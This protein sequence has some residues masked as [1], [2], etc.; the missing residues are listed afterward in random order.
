MTEKNEGNVSARH[1]SKAS[2]VDA[3][4]V[5][6]QFDADVNRDL[7]KLAKLTRGKEKV[8]S[9]V[10][11]LL[12]WLA[13][14]ELLPVTEAISRLAM[15]TREAAEYAQAEGDREVQSTL[16]SLLGNLMGQ[17]RD[18][19]PVAVHVEPKARRR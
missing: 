4:N 12:Q 2:R 8:D 11:H 5:R 16:T 15:V 3:E 7:A 1:A 13:S 10:H 14:G 6:I 9:D 19:Q 18:S 17:Q